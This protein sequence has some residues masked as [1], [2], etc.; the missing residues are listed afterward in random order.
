M[1]TLD[2][3][4]HWNLRKADDEKAFDA[5]V[6]GDVHLDL[7]R[8]GEIPDP[9]YRD[10]E[11]RLHW[12]GNSDWVY[13]RRF[14]VGREVL[15]AGR[16][17]LRCEGLDTLATVSINGEVV[18]EANNMFRTWEWEV[19]PV[20]R[21]GEN[22]IRVLFRSVNPEIAARQAEKFYAVGGGGT[23]KKFGTSQVRK[24]QCNSGWDWG[25][26]C[27]TAGI[28][29][30]IALV[31][32]DAARI[33]EIATR[34][35]HRDGHVDVT[36][37]VEAE[38]V[39]PRTSL[40]AEVALSGE[41]REIARDRI[42]L[43]DGKGEARLRVDAPRLW[44]PNGMGEQ[45]LYDLEV[46]LRDADG[47]P[48]DS[49][50]RRIGLR[51]IELV[52]EK[53]EW[54]ESFVFEVNG[55]R[56]FAKGANWIPG[57]VF[58]PRMTEGKY[59]D[60][61]QSAVD[62]H[63]NMIRVWG[64]GIYE[65]DVFYALCDELGLLVWQDFMY[66]C[67]AYPASRAEFLEN[68]RIEAEDTVRRLRHHPCIALYCGNNELE[69]CNFVGD[70]RE[71]SM[72]WDEYK[73]LF[74]ETLP[75][76]VRRLH[77]EISTI[78]SSAYSPGEAR[79]DPQADGCGDSHFWHVWNRRQPLEWYRSSLH[80]FCSE[81]GFQ[82]FPEP[83][84]CESFTAREDRNINSFVMN[85]HQR[86]TD[87]NPKA[88]HY[89]LEW[90]RLPSGFENT[91][92]MSQIMQGLAIKYA[93]E[94]WRRHMPRCMGALYWQLNDCWP[95]ASWASID[96]FGRWKAEH[97]M[98][99]RFFAPV[100][101][102]CLEDT[103]KG[104]LEL[105]VTSDLLEAKRAVLRWSATNAHGATLK[106]GELTATTPVNGS[107]HVETLDLSDVLAE[108]TPRDVLVW[109][110]LVVDEQ[111]VSENFVTFARPKDF[112]FPP[113]EIDVRVAAR[114]DGSFEVELAPAKPALWTWLSLSETD[115]R[116]SDNFVC[117]PGGSRRTV[118]AHPAAPLDEAEFK[119]QL[120]VR[121]L[122]DLYQ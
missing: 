36:V 14:E 77:A 52:Q 94:H 102:S 101:L 39:D 51:T 103:S 100:L 9:F 12:I 15:S 57:D 22:E 20:L 72:T 99:R 8:A 58:Q 31:A 16:V 32:V 66:A 50:R 48:V 42:P 80:R 120:R 82:S 44:W 7:L 59:R 96:Y 41:G 79:E 45:P 113:P 110:E 104:T 60:L 95:V 56:F 62:V 88:I 6:P 85:W 117:L 46:V 68:A 24:E 5:L 92:W 69:Q 105:H 49:Q 83:R 64:G 81:F 40:T 19:G 84:T 107:A 106:Q 76:V 43:A 89:I 109:L 21:E 27:V 33:A 63:M 119:R 65:E 29:R 67:A 55:R 47:N 112:L 34:Q 93:V 18:G 91:V 74:D 11:D 13:S 122:Y 108:N 73:L 4:G 53:D 61:L 3:T 25:P 78:P 70:K 75:D 28:W 2:L 38:A 35:E 54:G 17:L 115:A 114:G 90:H 37:G 118:A 86:N 97:Y 111:V 30:D 87:G 71:G 10:N 98:A 26:C 116:F 23:L 1:Q 121:S